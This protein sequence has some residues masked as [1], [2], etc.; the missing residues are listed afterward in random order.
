MPIYEITKDKLAKIEETS[1]EDVG[2]KERGDLQRLLRSQIEVISPDTLVIA[3]EFGE[4]ED[5]KRRIDLLGVDQD[6]NLVV[7]ELKRTGDGGH[8]DLQALRYAAM[9]STMTFEKAVEVCGSHLKKVG[10]TGKDGSAQD[11]LLEFLNWDE[12]DEDQFGQEVRLILVSA[13]F[14]KEL[15]TSVMWLNERGLDIRCVRLKP[16]KDNGRV[17]VDVEQVIPLPEAQEYQVKIREKAEKERLDRAGKSDRQQLHQQF[18]QGLLEKSKPRTDLYANVS[19]GKDHWLSAGS[20]TGGV[21]FTY[22]IT[23]NHARAALV[24]ETPDAELNKERFDQLCEHK[25]DIENECGGELIWRRGEG[26]KVASIVKESKWCGL[27]GDQDEWATAQ[28][29][30]VEAMVRLEKALRPYINAFKG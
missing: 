17:L 6:A 21:H 25:E 19:A 16:Y 13:D 30:M 2:V 4:W 5:S 15:T 14:S 26:K 1:F 7:I 3:E 28:D 22:S 10:D 27:L 9:V 8:M 20:G 24:L 12:P 11:A 29:A 23:R 18:W